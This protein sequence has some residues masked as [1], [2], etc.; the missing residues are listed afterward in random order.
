[1]FKLAQK[2]T[3][4]WPVHVDVPQDG[5]GTRRHTFEGEFEVLTQEEQDQVTTGNHSSGKTDLLDVVLLNYRRLK[6][7]TGND[8]EVNDANK[9][10]LLNI[11]YVRV[12]LFRSY[13]QIQSGL[14]ARKNA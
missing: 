10:L 1:M 14:G 2:R 7:E 5:G 4:W 11:Q 12:A 6:D 3:I 8:V 13:H 9:A